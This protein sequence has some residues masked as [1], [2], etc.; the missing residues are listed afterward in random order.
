LLLPGVRVKE[1]ENRG[2][3]K[4]G[5][6]KIGIHEGD[7]CQ[8]D[9]AEVHHTGNAVEPGIGAAEV[10]ARGTIREYGCVIELGC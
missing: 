1:G 5:G 3:I 9:A 4:L 8:I 6:G 7:T 10:D 2:L